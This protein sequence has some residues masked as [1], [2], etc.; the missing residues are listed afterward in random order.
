[1]NL[2]IGWV[3]PSQEGGASLIFAH[4]VREAKPFVFQ[5]ANDWGDPLWTDVRCRQ[6]SFE[7]HEYLFEEA[8]QEKLNQGIAHGI[9]SIPVCRKCELWGT[10][11]LDKEG[12]CLR[13]RDC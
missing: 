2:Y 13:C 5:I 12:L 6:L 10:G 9:D 4:S 11:K 8:D 7:T 1:M 3:G